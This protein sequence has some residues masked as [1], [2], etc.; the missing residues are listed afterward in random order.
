VELE[1][2][3]PGANGAE[4]WWQGAAALQLYRTRR[5]HVGTTLRQRH[6]GAAKLAGLVK[7]YPLR[8]V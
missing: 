7:Q 5:K 8:I 6:R 4:Q 2:G 3:S 1:G